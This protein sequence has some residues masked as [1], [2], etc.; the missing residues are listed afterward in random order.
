MNDK[1]CGRINQL[2]YYCVKQPGIYL[3]M[4]TGFLVDLMIQFPFMAICAFENMFRK[5]VQ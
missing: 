5:K 3:L 2:L 4:I 1:N